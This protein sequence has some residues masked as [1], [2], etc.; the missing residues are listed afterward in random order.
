MV[1]T[2][3]HTTIVINKHIIMKITQLTNNQHNIV[4][5]NDNI[6]IIISYKN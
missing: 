1:K 3:K 4:G 6:N 2:K 5:E